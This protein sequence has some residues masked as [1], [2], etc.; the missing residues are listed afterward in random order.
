MHPQNATLHRHER[1]HSAFLP[2]DRD[3][4]VWL[5]PGYDTESDHRYPVLYMHDGQNLFDPET[6]FQ[7]GEHWRV[8]ETAAEL[9][10]AGQLEPLIIVGISNTGEERIHE[11]TPTRDAWLGGGLAGDYGRLIVEDLKPLIDRTYR[12][13][14]DRQHTGLGGS[15]LGGLVT[16]HLGFTHPE[17]FSRLAVL[18]PSVWWDRRAILTTVRHARPKPAVRLWVHGHGRGPPRP[19][20]CAAVE[21]GV[22][23]RRLY[24]WLRSALRGVRRRDA[25]RGRMGGARRAHADVA[26]PGGRD[27]THA[28]S[29]ILKA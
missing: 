17:V 20:R 27:L 16:L 15:S 7:K 14:P 11:Y 25:Q 19:R 22:S 21:S 24:R 26:V 4:L 5:P 12:T 10:A 6:A 2:D 8:G 29:G 13:L 18:S 3:V 28:R 9:I 1:F 23:G